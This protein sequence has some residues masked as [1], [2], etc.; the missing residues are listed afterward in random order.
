MGLEKH[1]LICWN[2]LDFVC[3]ISEFFFLQLQ[4]DSDQNQGNHFFSETGSELNE[5]YMV[6]W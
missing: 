4:Y 6:V 5:T 1:F 3:L 2:P